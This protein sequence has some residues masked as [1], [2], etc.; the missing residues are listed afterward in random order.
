M[1][2]ETV[3]K[4]ELVKLGEGKDLSNSWQARTNTCVIER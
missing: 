4:M 1:L 2:A 3:V